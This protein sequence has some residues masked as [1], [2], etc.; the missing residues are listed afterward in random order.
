MQMKL[1]EIGSEKRLI[2][3]SDGVVREVS[4]N[5]DWHGEPSRTD[6]GCLE[7]MIMPVASTR[8]IALR[9]SRA[10]VVPL[11]ESRIRSKRIFRRFFAVFRDVSADRLVFHPRLPASVFLSV[12]WGAL[13]Y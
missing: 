1:R 3:L 11:I 13:S 7:N 5:G 12:D 6:R 4:F 2:R 8:R 9:D 10:S